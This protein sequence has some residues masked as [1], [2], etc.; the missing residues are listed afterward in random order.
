M[1]IKHNE[2]VKQDHET[3]RNGVGFY[4]FTHELIKVD[5]PEA[6]KFLDRILVNTMDA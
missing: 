3:I 4:D 5:G 1:S 6:G 2:Q